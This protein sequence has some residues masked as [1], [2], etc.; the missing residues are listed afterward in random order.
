MSGHA[1]RCPVC[2]YSLDGIEET[3]ACPECGADLGLRPQ[4]IEGY[5]RV[6]RTIED[7]CVIGLLCNL[8]WSVFLVMGGL[9]GIWSGL[10]DCGS[11]G[12]WMRVVV[13]GLSGALMIGL[14]VWRWSG[15][16]SRVY[17]I[18]LRRGGRFPS[19]WVQTGI[20]VVLSAIGIPLSFSLLYVVNT[21]LC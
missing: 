13:G 16:R 4:S 8:V 6:V 1:V 18:A 20:V 11:L 9:Y 14:L 2:R 12:S 7:W 5:E 21:V 10:T 15:T 3:G 17:R 19:V